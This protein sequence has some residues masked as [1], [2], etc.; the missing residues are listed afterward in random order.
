M[1]ITDLIK[2]KVLFFDGALGT[3]LQDRGIKYEKNAE[4]LNITNPDE[5]INIHV[6]YLNSGANIIKTNTFG[7]NIFKINDDAL[8][9]ET[10]KKGIENARESIKRCNDKKDKFVA[11][12]IGPTGKLIKPL[13]DL[14]FEDAISSYARLG[15]LAKKYK[16]DIILI[17]TLN[18]LYEIKASVLGIKETCDIP[19]FVSCAFEKSGRLMTGADSKCVCAMLEGLGVSAIGVNCS[20]GPKDLIGVIKTLNEVS[21]LPIIVNPNAGLPKIEDEKTK[22]DINETDFANYMQEILNIGAHFIGGCCGT[23]PSYIKALYEKFK[24]F[25][26]KKITKK[27]LSVITSNTKSVEFGKRPLII[28]ERINPTGKKLLKEAILSG[29]IDYILK[30]AIEEEENGADILDVNVGLGGIDEGEF[31]KNLVV[32]LQSVTSLPLQID[33]TNEVALEK[34][35]RVYSGK[36]LINS[37][38]ASEESMKK[39]F[40]IAKKYGAMIVGLT[41]DENNIPSDSVSRVN[42]AKKIVDGTKKYKIGK[43]ELVIDTLTMTVSTDKESAKVT[44][45]ALKK[46]SK[47]GLLSTLGVSNVSF[48]LPKREFLNQ[49]FF[50]MCLQN[51]LKSAIINPLSKEMMSSYKSFLALSGYDENFKDYIGY[52]TSMIDN[53]SS[54]IRKMSNETTDLK[55]AIIKGL[56]KTAYAI[57]QKLLKEKTPEYIIDEKIVPSLDIVGKGFEKGS[58]YLPELLI[59]AQSAKSSFDA[60]KEHLSKTGKNREKKI[61]IIIAT[62]KGD[63][64]DIGKNIVKALL[65]NY[66]FEVIDLG[67]DVDSKVILE[68]VIKHKAPLVGLS[69]LMTTTLD[70]MQDTISLL[71]EK[72]PFTKIMVGGAVLTGD[73]ATKMGADKYCKDAMEGVRYAESIYGEGM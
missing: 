43:N 23:S 14:E 49:T 67:K 18:D 12:D 32:K 41:L 52:A 61:K 40:P 56:D 22:F 35:L 62:V 57:T 27:N 59:C 7:A 39:V 6:E 2:E 24:D 68:S 31:L 51:G 50:T 48:G 36:A 33:T 25:K 11:L 44:I 45:D 3:L 64:H 53:M 72:A 58:V 4:S 38:N 46:I 10:I 5:I 47:M 21:S 8:L 9:E 19:I 1:K 60:I 17:E 26:P 42:L 63:I 29:D 15:S 13:G 16:P 30:M 37:V 71:K 73:Y 28:G 70:A 69:A 65:E 66:G 34:A 55:D 54:D 20:F